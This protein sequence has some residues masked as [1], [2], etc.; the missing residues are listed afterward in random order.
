[1][2]EKFKRVAEALKNNN[3]FLVKENGKYGFRNNAGELIVDCKYEDATEQNE[4]GYAAVKLNGKWGALKS[5]GAMILEPTV[6]LEENLYIDFIG[7]WH[8][9]KDL[10]LNAYTK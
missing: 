2:N 4:F 5:D 9:Y 7:E 10:R 8:L 1:M 3:L 6:D